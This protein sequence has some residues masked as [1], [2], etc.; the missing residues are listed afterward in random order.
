M[1]QHEGL[2]ITAEWTVR[3]L[4]PEGNVKWEDS[5]KN[6]T[7]NEGLDE[8]LEQAYLGSAYTAQHYVGLMDGTP[9]VAAGD[10][11]SSHAG[12]S[13]VQAY[14]EANRG[15][16]TTALGTVS[17]QSLSTSATID[18]SINADS[19]TIGGAFISTDNTIGGTTGI[20]I[21]ASA[22]SG[23]DKSLDNGDTLQVS[24]TLTFA[25]A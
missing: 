7:V 23:G 24:V 18:F 22:F 14:D 21:G 20:L 9:T 12:W 25:S 4:D 6:T 11:I 1:R 13:E 10:A 17:G 2:K 15:D 19:T 3:G 5:Y 8:L 16:L